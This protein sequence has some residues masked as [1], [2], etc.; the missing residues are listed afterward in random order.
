MAAMRSASSVVIGTF[1]AFLVLFFVHGPV[2][3]RSKYFLCQ[4]SRLSIL[5]TTFVGDFEWIFVV[6]KLGGKFQLIISN[7]LRSAPVRPNGVNINNLIVIPRA[8]TETW[9]CNVVSDHFY[10]RDIC[11]EGCRIEQIPRDYARGGGV[12][13]VY[14]KCFKANLNSSVNVQSFELIDVQLTSAR[15]RNLRLAVIYRPPPSSMNSFT[16]GLFLDELSSFL[17]GLVLA[18][19]ALLVAGDFNLHMDDQED[20][21][22]RR[23]LQVLELFDLTQYVSHSTHKYGNTPDLIITRAND[24]LVGKCFVHDPLI[25]DHLPF[26]VSLRLAKLPPERRTMSYRRIRAIDFHEL[27][28]DLE[29]SSLVRDAETSDLSDFVN[30][31]NNTLKSLLDTYAPLRSKTNTL[32]PTASWYND[33]IRSEKRRRRALERRWRFKTRV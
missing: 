7:R 24:D 17:E 28:R 14:K 33:E 31:Y 3:I 8:I 30:K 4:H 27:C 15:N 20:D 13:L 10:F 9:L 25:S 11:L 29:N 18:P 6:A 26:H 16:V 23:F 12:V 32:R 22:A 2:Q 1:Y 5:A 21:D 19:S